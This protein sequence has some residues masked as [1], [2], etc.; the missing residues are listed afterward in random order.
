MQKAR[1]KEPR[2]AL[3]AGSVSFMKLSKISI[4][5]ASGMV[6]CVCRFEVQG[7][8]VDVPFNIPEESLYSK[9]A[10]RGADSWDNEDLILLGSEIVGQQIQA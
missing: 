1:Q 4:D 7:V 6:Y 9:A 2:Q 5:V 10:E 3:N 8:V